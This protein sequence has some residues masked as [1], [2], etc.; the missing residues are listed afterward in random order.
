MFVGVNRVIRAIDQLH[1]EVNQRVAGDSARL[2]RFDYSFLNSGAK[3]LWHRATKDLVFKQKPPAARRGFEDALALAK[4]P[5]AT[6][7]FLVSSL[8]FG[9]LRYRFLVRNLWRMKRY[10]DAVTLLQFF[11][12]CFHVQLTRA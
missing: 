8:Q 5:A 1:L 3:L 6:S 4:L 10:F 7:L 11:Y 2:C 12:D 9:S